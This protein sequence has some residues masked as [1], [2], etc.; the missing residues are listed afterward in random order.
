METHIYQWNNDAHRELIES[1]K[2]SSIS[3]SPSNHAAL[4]VSSSGEDVSRQFCSVDHTQKTSAPKKV[5]EGGQ[6]FNLYDSN[7]DG[8]I[9]PE[10]LQNAMLLGPDECTVMIQYADKNRDG[11]LDLEG[12]YMW[13]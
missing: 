6:L 7:R 13:L 2:H 4:S 11:F 1:K 8:K 5:V 9:S 10:E 3:P 12:N